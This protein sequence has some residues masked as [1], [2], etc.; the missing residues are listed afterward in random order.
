MRA[1]AAEL[2]V[3]APALYWHVR[4][5]EDLSLLL[6]DHL[7]SDLDYGAPSG[8]WRADM[9]RMAQALRAR[10]VDTRDI[11]RLFPDD[12]SSGPRAARPLE[13]SLGLLR[14]AGLPGPDA[15]M[16]YGVALSFIVGWARFEATRRAQAKPAEALPAPSPNLAWALAGGLSDPEAGFEFGLDLLIAGLERRLERQ[17]QGS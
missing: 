17:A 7:I 16:A 10:L 14:Q 11:T 2:N 5:K 1:V 6:F 4:S 3:K 9:R 12:Y 8:D 13:M 15:L